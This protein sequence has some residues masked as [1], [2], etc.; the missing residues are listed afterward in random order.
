MAEKKQKQKQQQQQLDQQKF[1]NGFWPKVKRGTY[2]DADGHT[3]PLEAILSDLPAGRAFVPGC[4]RGYDSILLAEGDKRVV[5]GLDISELAVQEAVK[6][7]EERKV[8]Q[9]QVD[10]VCGDFFKF[11][12]GHRFDVIFDYTFLC[13]LPPEL[14][15]GWAKQMAALLTKDQGRLVTLIFPIVDRPG[16][17]PY[18]MTVELVEKLLKPHGFVRV[19]LDTKVKGSHIG[20]EGKEAMAI[21]KLPSQKSVRSATAA[22]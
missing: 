13:A 17:P 9:K 16:G 7:R 14:R 1:W 12:P 4:G 5:T 15:E 2:F 22:D 18:A 8:D 6:Y 3:K 20:R 19:S 11:S 21:W 10:Y